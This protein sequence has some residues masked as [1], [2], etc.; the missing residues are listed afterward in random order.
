MVISVHNAA[1]TLANMARLA[2]DAAGNVVGMVSSNAFRANTAVVF[3]DSFSNRNNQTSGTLL[4]RQMDWG[5]FTWANVFCN[6]AFT[7]LANHGVSGNTTTQML[8]RID[9]ALVV[10]AAWAFVQGGVND[11]SAGATADQIVANLK[12]ICRRFV[13]AGANVVLCGIAPYTGYAGGYTTILA[14]N[15][16]L[17]EYYSTAPNVVF[18]DVYQ[19]LVNPTDTTGALATGMSDDALHPSAKGAR[20][21]GQAIANAI[22]G[23]YS[24]F[25]YLPSSAADSYAIDAASKQLLTNPLMSGTGGS[26]SGTGASGTLANGWNGGTDTGTVTSVFAAGQARSD[27]VGVDQQ[28]TIS[29][30]GSG[31]I[32]NMRQTGLASRVAIGDTVYA[33]GSI[34][35]SGCSDLLY[36]QPSIEVTIDGVTSR[37]RIF[38]NASAVWDQTNLTINFRTPEF[39]LAGTT[40]TALNYFIRFGFGTSGTGA[41]VAKIGRCGLLK[42]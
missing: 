29:S 41:A 1:S 7:L 38:D 10:G 16:A 13:A 18:V 24:P 2:T 9:Q 12:E 34:S 22:A 4:Y 23:R 17:R 26:V 32:V 31:A 15:K 37:V 40:I 39:T 36:V 35:L 20:A 6:G 14:V 42:R 28:I 5:Y 3:G 30:A 8:A 21:Y 27:G 25:N 33:V 11:V 19:A